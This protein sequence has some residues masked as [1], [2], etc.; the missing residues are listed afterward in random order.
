MQDSAREVWHTDLVVWSCLEGWMVLQLFLQRQKR[1][2]SHR[3][4]TWLYIEVKC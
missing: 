3:R 2:F 1:S 4:K